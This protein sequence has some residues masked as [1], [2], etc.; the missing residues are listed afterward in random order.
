VG[1]SLQISRDIPSK[2]PSYILKIMGK[3]VL[4]TSVLLNVMDGNVIML[5]KVVPADPRG[6]TADAKCEQSRILASSK[7]LSNIKLI[8]ANYG[9][10]RY[11]P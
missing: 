5:C 10:C 3:F 8:T 6:L 9:T 7:E 4:Y 1:I 2:C 11:T